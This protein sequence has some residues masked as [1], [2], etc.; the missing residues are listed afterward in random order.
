MSAHRLNAIF[1]A[2]GEKPAA[3][4]DKRADGRLVES[5]EKNEHYF[6]EMSVWNLKNF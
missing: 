1:G 5:D 4:A 3:V 6:H 2:G